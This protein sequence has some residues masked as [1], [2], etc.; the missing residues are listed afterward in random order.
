MPI[1]STVTRWPIRLFWF[2]VASLALTGCSWMAPQVTPPA[3]SYRAQDFDLQLAGTA[4]HVKVKGAAVSDEFFAAGKIR[5]ILGRAILP[6]EHRAPQVALISFRLWNGKF[7]GD[8]AAIGRTVQV[9]GQNAT[10]VGVMANDFSFPDG[11]QLWIPLPA[12]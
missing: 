10:I 5:P 1:P 11:A 6:G 7:H 4:E 9:D 12:R 3:G 2:Y 8:P